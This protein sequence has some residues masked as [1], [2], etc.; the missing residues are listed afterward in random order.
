[1][2]ANFPFRKKCAQTKSPCFY[3]QRHEA[4]EKYATVDLLIN[5]GQPSAWRK[6]PNN[7]VARGSSW[8]FMEQL[9]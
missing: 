9:K 8:L 6:P 5:T 2:Y 1:M 3:A 4:L 7:K